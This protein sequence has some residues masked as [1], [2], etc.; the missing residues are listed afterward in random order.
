MTKEDKAFLV[1]F[2]MGEPDWT[3]FELP[4]FKDYPSVQW[5]LIN[6]LKL[7]KQNPAKLRTESERLQSIF[8]ID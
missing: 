3:K 8:R 2:E 4:Y 6:L 7:K 1:S 5:K